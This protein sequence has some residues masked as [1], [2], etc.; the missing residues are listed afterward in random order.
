MQ[1][2]ATVARG[3]SEIINHKEGRN[4]PFVV[5]W[6][7]G[8]IYCRW[9]I[10]KKTKLTSSGGCRGR[11]LVEKYAA[12]AGEGGGSP[13]VR[14]RKPRGIKTIIDDGGV[15]V[16]QQQAY[17]QLFLGCGDGDGTEGSRRFTNPEAGVV[18]TSESFVSRLRRHDVKHPTAAETGRFNRNQAEEQGQFRENLYGLCGVSRV[19]KV[20]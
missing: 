6:G 7:A 15:A 19:S 10:R 20:G 8:G 16:F 5:S 11:P 13:N 1:D 18:G 3:V 4:R 17:W 12:P 2:N 9:D 14:T